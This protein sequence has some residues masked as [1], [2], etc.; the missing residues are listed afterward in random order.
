M[1]ARQV[2]T[3][4]LKELT[5]ALRDRRTLV[6]MFVV[7]TLLIPV[8]FFA[9]G[10]FT[11][12]IMRKARAET[13]AVMVMGGAD[14]PR[15]LSALRSHPR[16][17]LLPAAPDFRRRISDK[18]LRAAIEIPAGFD[19]SIDEGRPASVRIFT[20]EG[21]LRSNFAAGEI[22]RFLR[23]YREKLIRTRLE[24]RGIP[25]SVLKPFEITRENVAP[26]EKV[27]GNLIGGLIPC[28]II[29]LSFS[30]AMYPAMDLTAGE[31]ERGTMETLLCSPAGRREIALGKF[32]MVLTASLATVL[33]SA[34]STAATLATGVFLLARDTMAAVSKTADG[35]ARAALPS[36]DPAGFLLSLTMVLPVA[37]LFSSGLIALSLFAKSYKEAQSYVSP[38]VIVVLLPA[39]LATLPGVDLNAT[40]ACVPIL[41]VA[42]LC[43]ELVSGIF[44]WGYISL[45]FVST[46]VYAAL[47]L[48]LAER[49][50]NRESVLFRS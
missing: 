22:D 21:E 7:P 29:L 18:S 13:Q 26:P 8:M 1:N 40:L 10:A 11:T 28:V 47:G 36:I 24:D 50:F 48:L 9:F 35:A 38:L 16:L 46:S 44:N 45:I 19:R 6:S 20:Y 41:N 49:M 3:V 4:Y 25:R 43:K 5:D 42:L 27:G 12:R 34:L 15:V 17:K 31:K 32:L 14:S 37:V 2:G 39:M 23:E 30:G 33:L